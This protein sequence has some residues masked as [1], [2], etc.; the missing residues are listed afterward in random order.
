L[1]HN[2]GICGIIV[3]DLD[4]PPIVAQSLLSKILDEFTMKN[5]ASAWARSD[6]KIPFP[7]LKTYITK[8]QNPSEADSIMKIQREL[9]ETKIILHKTI[10]SVLERGEKIDNLVQ[11]S[12]GLSTASK[13]FYS[14]FLRNLI[15]QLPAFDSS[16]LAILPLCR[17]TF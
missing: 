14:E 9:D 6:P 4:Y 5:P 3:S 15:S 8:Y 1:G 13:A 17:C 11:K 16:T 10:E 12:E 7:E 2:T